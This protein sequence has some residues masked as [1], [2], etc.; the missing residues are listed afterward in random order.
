MES[1]ES[2][3]SYNTSQPIIIPSTVSLTARVDQSVTLFARFC[4][5]PP[6]TAILWVGPQVL[7]KQGEERERFV[8]H[9]APDLQGDMCGTVSLQMEQV[10]MEDMGEYLLVVRNIYGIQEGVMWLEVEGLDVVSSSRR[11]YCD[12]FLL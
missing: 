9:P 5:N 3:K 10:E 8:A 12:I 6:P 7:L 1:E 2:T 11:S 4:S